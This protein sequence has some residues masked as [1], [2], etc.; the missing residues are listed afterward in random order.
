MKIDVHAEE[1][2]R[3]E[4]IHKTVDGQEFTGVRFQR[5]DGIE[6]T[7]WGKTDLRL[8]VRKLAALLD[9]HYAPR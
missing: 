8:E 3:T 1:I 9:A 2:A 4:I 6:V 5:S 7:F